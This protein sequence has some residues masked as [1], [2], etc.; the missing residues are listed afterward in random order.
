[1]P[2]KLIWRTPPFGR[3]INFC[4][5][6]ERFG[7]KNHRSSRQNGTDSLEESFPAI[8]G[9]KPEI[10]ILLLAVEGK[11]TVP[12]PERSVLSPPIFWRTSNV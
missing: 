10:F 8:V 4:I 6:H 5:L 9:M 3:K 2:I 11:C 1:M 12:S 7:N